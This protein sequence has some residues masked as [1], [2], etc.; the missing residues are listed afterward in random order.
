MKKKNRIIEQKY[1]ISIFVFF[2]IFG[3]FLGF[4]VLA[5]TIQF[6]NP[7][8]YKV[9]I[10]EPND[11][12]CVAGMDGT[13]YYYNQMTYV[14][15]GSA[16]IDL[17]TS[18]TETDPQVG[19][20]TSGNFCK[21]TGTAVSCTDASTYLTSYSETDP[22]VVTVTSGNFCKG[23][24]TAVSCT[25]ASTYLT[26][27]SE[28]DPQVGTLT[29][30]KWCT[31]NGSVVN[32]TTNPPVTEIA[33]IY[34]LNAGDTMTG[35]LTMSGS[36]ANII[37]GSNYLSGDGGDEGVFVNSTG[38]VGIGTTNPQAKLHVQGDAIITGGLDLSA[39]DI[40][41]NSV[42]ASVFYDKDNVNY[43]VDPASATNLNILNVAS[44]NSSLTVNSTGKFYS[45]I[46][47][48]DNVRTGL[49]HYDT[50]AQAAG[51]GGQIVLG[52]K[53]TDAGSYTEGAIIKMY[54]ENATTGH[55]GSGIKFQV[56]NTGENLATQV[57]IDPSGKVG[58]GTTSPQATL[59]VAGQIR[60]GA[61]GGN[62]NA[63]PK[64]YVDGLGGG[65]VYGPVS[66]TDNAIARFNTTTGKLI[67]NSGVTIDDSNNLVTSGYLRGNNGMYVGD[68]E[69]FW[70]DAEDRIATTDDFY[71][72]GSS[73]NTY[74][75]STNT[76]LG[77]SSGDNIQVRDNK[78]YGDDWTIN[79]NQVGNWGIGITIPTSLLHLY[80]ASTPEITLETNTTSDDFGI[81]F[82]AGDS[83]E[84][85]SINYFT[86]TGSSADDRLIFSEQGNSV[87]VLDSAGNVG[88]G[89]TNPGYKL[90]V[91]GTLNATTLYQAE[92]TLD[93]RYIATTHPSNLLSNSRFLDYT[94]AI[95]AR[96]WTGLSAG[97]REVADATVNTQTGLTV[98]AWDDDDW[99]TSYKY[100]WM[101][102]AALNFSDT[103]LVG[104]YVVFAGS[105]TA[106]LE[107]YKGEIVEVD[108]GNNK[109]RL[110][111]PRGY[112]SVIGIPAT[113]TV[114]EQY[115][116]AAVANRS[117]KCV[118]FYA[119]QGN[120]NTVVTSSYF[121]IPGDTKIAIS[122]DQ[123]IKS[124][125][126]GGM[127]VQ[128]EVTDTDGKKVYR[129]G[130]PGSSTTNTDNWVVKSFDA[131]GPFN[132]T[133]NWN[134]GAEVG[135]KITPTFLLHI[136]FKYYDSTNAAEW[137]VTGVNVNAGEKAYAY[138]PHYISEE[139]ADV[140]LQGDFTVNGKLT[141]N[142]I[143]PPYNID[144]VIYATY[145]HSTTGLKEETTGKVE[146]VNQVL[147][148]SGNQDQYYYIIDFD[149]V[150]TESDLWL[151]KEITA[152]GNDW[153]DLVVILTPEGRAE[154]WY[155]FIP[156]ENKIIIYGELGT[157]TL[158]AS[159][160]DSPLKVSYRLMAPR[161]D[162]PERDTNLYDGTGTAPEGVGIFIR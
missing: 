81:K 34:V 110:S 62:D 17:T 102:D 54:K 138:T 65:D 129:W 119:N 39:A 18:A 113:P 10:S 124:L 122:Y 130:G 160:Q 24:G 72:Q 116:I 70:S 38:N 7:I 144:G 63:V 104:K 21:G 142:E 32:C 143:D 25:D 109:V 48:G 153:N 99:T 33:D 2:I 96:G 35:P 121:T 146:L 60:V 111:I 9:Q 74:L 36:S 13:V 139:D 77:A 50:T 84:R 16:W 46:G 28:T 68:D 19:T 97:K 92:Q 43:Y 148:Y 126:T 127:Y 14:C 52:Y 23:T 137:Y 90:D 147:R 105:P 123:Y 112:N 12:D 88:I 135:A 87:M 103:Y 31:T 6:D 101:T 47:S 3:I 117:T 108:S 91:S 73:S 140:S 95:I 125:G 30:T 100:V 150:E 98:D 57:V 44:I 42:T 155:E 79:Y 151:F 156:E 136:M 83:S 158:G 20:V 1:W 162:W 56:R 152:F 86:S 66:A 53:Y 80:K 58:I 41:A 132:N 159:P 85:F 5:K 11:A 29:N 114:G 8:Q 55:Y 133:D 22:Q 37:L 131:L 115:N 76:Y 118:K 120:H 128:F 106:I 149:D 4:N 157:G 45:A 107:G 141:A 93:D 51:V 67:Q 69:Y 64:S 154:V 61:Y 78:M 75:Y 89:V 71:V 145:G 15:N 27:Y 26:S 134:N 59:D 82:L 94:S 161:F 49:A 40:T